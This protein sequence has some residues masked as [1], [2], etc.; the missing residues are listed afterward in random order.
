MMSL[1]DE[2]GHGFDETGCAVRAPRHPVP[3]TKRGEARYHGR[4]QALSRVAAREPL[5]LE[6]DLK[7]LRALPIVDDSPPPW[8]APAA[9]A[10]QPTLLDTAWFHLRALRHRAKRAVVDSLPP[11]L[12]GGEPVARRPRASAEDEKGLSHVLARSSTPLWTHDDPKERPLV[13]GKVHNLRV[14]CRRIDGALVPAGGVFS[15]W[16]EVGPPWAAFGFVEGRELREGCLVPSV[17]GGLCQLSNALYG[18]ALDAGFEIVERHGHTVTLVGSAAAT[19]RDATVFWNYVDLRFRPDTDCLVEARV[20]GD[21][22]EVKMRAAAPPSGRSRAI[23]HGTGTHQVARPRL[24]VADHSCDTCGQEACAVGRQARR[25][26]KPSRSSRT[27]WVV[28]EHLPELAVWMARERGAGDVIALPLP[29][30]AWG[31]PQYAWDV[32]GLEVVGA[33]WTALRRARR[34]RALQDEGARRVAA[35]LASSA[36]L[37]RSYARRLGADVDRV[38]CAQSLVPFLWREQAL[39]G[40]RFEVFLHRLPLSVLHERLD[41]A[42]ARFPDSSLLRAY[43]APAWMVEAESEALSLADR[44]VTAHVDVAQAVPRAEL[45]PWDVAAPSTL[46]VCAGRRRIVFPGPAAARKGAHAVREA[47]RRLGLVVVLAGSDLEG[48]GFWQ[49]VDVERTTWREAFRRPVRAVVQ[50]ALVEERPR[51][52]LEAHAAGAKVIVTRACGLPEGAGLRH[53]PFDDVDALVTALGATD[54][55]AG[56]T[57]R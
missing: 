51:R 9:A 13:A 2:R 41:A 39:G 19:S 48:D 1:P 35:Q 27:A 52:L 20:V 6:D 7:P 18:C 40:R 56:R 28:D 26:V 33:P 53:V 32:G 55:S 21:R 14:A 46:R 57:G 54:P 25:S 8:P 38:V 11:R 29:G 31:L 42:A 45:V 17:G 15:F 10:P 3:D 43:R 34:M 23:A 36:E 37:A 4:D 24:V 16:S 22:L 50:P 5:R 30:R 49:G 44:L 12:G 47:T